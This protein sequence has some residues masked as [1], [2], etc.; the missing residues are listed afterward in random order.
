MKLLLLIIFSVSAQD[1]KFLDEAI[2]KAKLEKIEFM[3]KEQERKNN[4]VDEQHKAILNILRKSKLKDIDPALFKSFP[5]ELIP[6]SQMLQDALARYVQMLSDYRVKIVKLGDNSK[7][8]LSQEVQGRSLALHSFL[9]ISHH[10]PK[11]KE[12]KGIE[13]KLED[14]L[15]KKYLAKL[16]ASFLTYVDKKVN[17]PTKSK[18][19]LN[20][21]ELSHIFQKI[22][23]FQSDDFG[24]LIISNMKLP[25]RKKLDSLI[26][27]FREYKRTEDQLTK[28]K[29]RIDEYL[30]THSVEY[31]KDEEFHNLLNDLHKNPDRE[32]RSEEEK[33]AKLMLKIFSQEHCI[34]N[35]VTFSNKAL[36]EMRKKT[37][38]N[39][40]N[41]AKKRGVS[42]KKQV[43][44]VNMAINSINPDILTPQMIETIMLL[45]GQL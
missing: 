5:K 15:F 44:D 22:N 19:G 8:K 29:K 9:N 34:V 17:L 21:V 33:I 1:N 12:L 11:F 28:R 35:K 4:E 37:K 16:I 41:I 13:K 26:K 36:Q 38:E 45:K 43:N 40:K 2:L 6:D 18:N 14:P 42:S 32:A 10:L 3:K 39:F 27:L 31:E 25:K 7:S 24:T 30:K 20:I 23:I